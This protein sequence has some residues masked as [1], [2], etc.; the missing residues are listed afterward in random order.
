[1]ISSVGLEHYLDKVGVTGSS[2]VLPTNKIL[3]KQDFFVGPLGEEV[4]AERS[5]AELR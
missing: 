3:Q 5:K 1:V 4:Y 2:P